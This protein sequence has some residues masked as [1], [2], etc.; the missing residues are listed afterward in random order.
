MDEIALVR[1]L[2]PPRPLPHPQELSAAHA[3]LVDAVAHSPAAPP[4]R[5]RRIVIAGLT[6]TSVAA[7][8]T[9]VLVLAPDLIGDDVP[10]A[11]AEAALIL[12][13]A[14]DAALLTPELQPRPDQFLYQ[15]NGGGYESWYSVDGTRDG[16]TQGPTGRAVFPGCR[17]GERAIIKGDDQ[18]IGT[19]P[20]TPD[21]AYLPELPT[22][23][24]AMLQYLYRRYAGEPGDANAIGKGILFLLKDHYL[25]PQARAAVFDAAAA[26]P[27]LSV[28]EHTTDGVGRPGIGIAWSADGKTGT[29]VFDADTFE[30]LGFRQGNHASAEVRVAIVDDVGQRP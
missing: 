9:A 25:R 11:N 14:A 7:A 2:A 30:Y 18:V 27:G 20:C 19:E 1:E 13:R 15:D 28:V 17:D 5:S 10:Q 22:D 29:I 26:V 16:L 24:G 4:R 3:Q 21:P 6:A 8:L 23:A 12:H